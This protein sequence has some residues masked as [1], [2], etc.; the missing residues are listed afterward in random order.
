MKLKLSLAATLFAVVT[1]F[2]FAFAAFKGRANFA[3]YDDLHAR[4]VLIGKPKEDAYILLGIPTGVNGNEEYWYIG[5]DKS[6]ALFPDLYFFYIEVK[7]GVIV[8]T[9]LHTNKG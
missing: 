4:Q 1:L 8:N 9:R 5:E 7:D 6:M 3:F 2:F